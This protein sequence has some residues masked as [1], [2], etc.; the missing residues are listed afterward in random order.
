MRCF[1]RCQP[2]NV[3]LICFPHAGGSAGFFFPYSRSLAPEIEVW[4]IQYPGRQDRRHERLID[5][6]PELADR[7]HEE[8]TREQNR[9]FAFFGHSMGA[10]VA[11]EVAQRLK[12]GGGVSPRWLFASGR[13]APAHRRVGEVH[14][15]DD[16]GL[17][18]EL[19]SVGGT[20][21]LFLQDEELLAAILP[22]TRNDYR[23]IETYAWE[24]GPELDCPV[25]ALVGEGDP[26]VTTAEAADWATHTTGPFE[27]RT[28]PGGHFYLDAH[29]AAV[30][31]TV[32]TALS[33]APR[34]TSSQG[35]S[36]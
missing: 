5:N 22:V 1:Q 6:I 10:V 14:L 4:A 31:D 12:R 32:S 25:T 3:R 15:R 33:A 8:V 2:E 20:N 35:S 26:Q 11:F 30:L 17:I 29:R 36:A 7:I 13:R 28:F 21:Q 19:L 23:A 16:A 24:G 34:T 18:E 9:P 27:L